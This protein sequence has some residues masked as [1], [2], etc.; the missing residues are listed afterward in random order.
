MRTLLTTLVAIWGICALV[1]CG[2]AA[3]GYDGVSRFAGAYGPFYGPGSPPR[4]QPVSEVPV[5]AGPRGA[6]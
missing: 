1:A 2:T 6:I 4:E 3:G 5:P